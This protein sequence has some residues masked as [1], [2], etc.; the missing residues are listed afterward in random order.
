MKRKAESLQVAAFDSCARKSVNIQ[1]LP[2]DV[3]DDALC[4]RFVYVGAP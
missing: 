4:P 2:D 1:D 3:R